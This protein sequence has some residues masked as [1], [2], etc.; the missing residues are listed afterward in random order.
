MLKLL[1]LFS[2]ERDRTTLGILIQPMTART[3]SPTLLKCTAACEPNTL[4]V[5]SRKSASIKTKKKK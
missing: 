4:S 1:M 3:S 5:K 2:I